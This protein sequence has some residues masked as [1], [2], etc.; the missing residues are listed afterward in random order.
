[1]NERTYVTR[2]TDL[3]QVRNVLK[4]ISEISLNVMEKHEELMCLRC[5]V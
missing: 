5:F 1:M 3:R 4:G 2:A